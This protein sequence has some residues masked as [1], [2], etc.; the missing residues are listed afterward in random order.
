M[1]IKGS[2]VDINYQ[3]T[4]NFFKKRA[5]KYQEKLPYA[6]TMYQDKHPELVIERNKAEVE[7]LRPLLNLSETSRV[8]DVMCGIGRWADV[9]PD[10]ID[11]YCGIDFSDELIQIAN[12]RKQNEKFSFC[13]GAATEIQDTLLK[14]G[15]GKYNT[16][17]LI[18]AL[19]YLNDDDLLQTLRQIEAVCEEHAVICIREPVGLKERLTL[20]NFFSDELE[21]MYN[22]IYRTKEELEEE[23]FSIF[24]G[25]NFHIENK[26]F[27]F[28]GGQKHLNNRQETAQHYW[29]L[30]R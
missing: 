17:L 9:M 23:F 28:G 6:T 11:A 27:L 4:K 19:M 8:L 14:N 12:E 21:D 24:L 5:E 15:K 1:R 10:M 20:K 18:G 22:A 3:D 7:C 26:N 29:I 13:V 25:K 16:I 2:A 30:R